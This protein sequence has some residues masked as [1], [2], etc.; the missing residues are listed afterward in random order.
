MAALKYLVLNAHTH[1]EYAGESMYYILK[2][3]ILSDETEFNKV[4]LD[5]LLEGIC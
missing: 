5:S 3:V 1:D 4:Y 2:K